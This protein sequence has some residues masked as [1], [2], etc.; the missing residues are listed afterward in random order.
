MESSNA[1]L[2]N[3]THL[4]YG[5]PYYD[6]YNLAQSVDLGINQNKQPAPPFTQLIT[7]Y[8]SSQ[9]GYHQ[10]LHQAA[11]PIYYTNS[12]TPVMQAQVGA[13]P[14]HGSQTT[15]WSPGP[16]QDSLGQLQHPTSSNAGRGGHSNPGR[17]GHTNSS[18]RA[19]GRGRG[20][21]P[22]RSQPTFTPTPTASTPTEPP[23]SMKQILDQFLPK[24]L[25]TMLPDT[26]QTFTPNVAHELEEVMKK[27]SAKEISAAE[28]R[29]V[30]ANRCKKNFSQ[31]DGAFFMALENDL[32]IIR[33]VYCLV[34]RVSPE[35]ASRHM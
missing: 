13:N 18:V 17:V 25:V 3:L 30:A 34:R 22:T 4:A 31:A 15:Y 9:P 28:V 7:P 5:Q 11:A 20:Q 19:R 32:D 26:T 14:Q 21:G 24:S 1:S 27:V 16:R 29:V 23:L 2:P 8:P 6:D 10:G 35:R 33:V 12:S